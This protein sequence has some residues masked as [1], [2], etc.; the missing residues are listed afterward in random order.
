MCVFTIRET[1]V[2]SSICQKCQGTQ[3]KAFLCFELKGGWK[4]EG[5]C[6]HKTASIRVKTVFSPMVYKSN[7]SFLPKTHIL[8]YMTLPLFARFLRDTLSISF[9]MRKKGRWNKNKM[10]VFTIRETFVLSSICQKCQG[11]E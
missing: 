2:F 6:D 9:K 5:D 7:V 1:I 3:I 8:L 10:C 11:S 4:R